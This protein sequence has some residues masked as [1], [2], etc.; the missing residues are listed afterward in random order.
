MDKTYHY[1]VI[2]HA[3]REID[4]AGPTLTLEVLADRMGM[5]AAHFQRVFS[6]WVGVSPKRYQQYL[7]LDHARSLL[8][9]RFNVSVGADENFTK[10][11]V[12]MVRSLYL[13]DDLLYVNSRY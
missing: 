11:T 7:T 13:K 3:L 8:A 12:A 4:A 10:Y 6:A 5:S 1:S 9:D 2:E